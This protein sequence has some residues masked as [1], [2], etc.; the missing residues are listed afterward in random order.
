MK[1][2]TKKIVLI[3]FL[4][5]ISLIVLST[6]VGATS[7]PV[8]LV[9][10]KDDYLIYIENL[11]N[12]D[13]KF[14]FSNG[15]GDNLNLQFISNWE[16]TN[17]VH[18]AALEKNAEVDL[19]KTVYLLIEEGEGE[20]KTN[21]SIELDLSKAITKEEMA[22]IE[23]VTKVIK[24][25]AKQTTTTA[26]N[27]NGIASTLTVGQINITDSKEFNYKYQLIKIDESASKTAKDLIT[28]INSLQTE[29]KDMSMYNK[30]NA[31]TE[32][33]DLYTSLQKEANWQDVKDMVIY[34]PEDSKEGDQYIVLIQQL[35]KDKILKRDI[36]FLKCTDGHEEEYVKEVKE[37]KKATALPVTYDSIIL[38]VLLAVIVLITIAVIIR[39]RKLNEEK[40]K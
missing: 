27:E 4:I 2:F 33:R 17:G 21:T 24:I 37:I 10:V 15:E 19:S 6:K 29:Y 36:Q 8:A 38:I 30:I 40:N 5:L 16:D 39:M 23:D 3:L 20:N 7:K 9:K 28:L 14:A 22:N 13:F 35:S 31:I 25:D 12:K 26:T 18:I 34:Q 11:E 32:V 1:N